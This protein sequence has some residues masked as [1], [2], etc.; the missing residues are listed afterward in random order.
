[1]HHVTVEATLPGLPLHTALALYVLDSL[2]YGLDGRMIK[3]GFR[4]G[5]EIVIIPTEWRLRLGLT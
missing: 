3:I 1:M 5:L 4:Q 2:G